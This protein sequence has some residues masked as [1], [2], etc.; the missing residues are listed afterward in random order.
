MINKIFEVRR[1]Y[2]KYYHATPETIGS[3]IFMVGCVQLIWGL[4]I[5]S[6]FWS[7]LGENE[8]LAFL[9]FKGIPLMVSEFIWGGITASIG[10][11]LLYSLWNHS[12]LLRLVTLMT[13][14]AL[15]AYISY[16]VALENFHYPVIILYFFVLSMYLYLLSKVPLK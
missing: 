12:A 16:N 9:P 2:M 10:L 6:P 11:S 4:W 5:A 3:M 15:W 13:G 7:A 1:Y 14:T 8:F